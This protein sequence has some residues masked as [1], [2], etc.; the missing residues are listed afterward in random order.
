MLVPID[1]LADAEQF[2]A[3]LNSSGARLI[4]TTARHLDA[5]GAILRA[6][7]VTAI[8]IDED[9]RSG[10]DATPG[11][12]LADKRAKDLPVPAHD[13]PAVV[14]DHAANPVSSARQ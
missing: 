1:D 5:S 12:D 13:A 9:G 3:A 11:P 8:C 7:N 6:H 10:P 4:L 2:D 14:A